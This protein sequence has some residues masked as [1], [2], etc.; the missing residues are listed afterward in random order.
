MFSRLAVSCVWCRVGALFCECCFCVF[1]L[2]CFS[3]H[4]IIAPYLPCCAV[5]FC[6]GDLIVPQKPGPLGVGSAVI[7]W[8]VCMLACVVSLLPSSSMLCSAGCVL[9][10][11]LVVPLTH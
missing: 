5:G 6:P 1:C 9:Y 4:C 3:Q 11:A 7:A 8:F 2:L 10:A